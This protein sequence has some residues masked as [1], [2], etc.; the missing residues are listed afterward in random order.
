MVNREDRIYAGKLSFE[1]TA[2][3]IAACAGARG[4]NIDYLANTVAHLDEMGIAEG[5]LHALLRRAR[6]LQRNM[7]K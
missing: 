7:A 4:P 1:E 5:H 2:R 3:Q 6:T